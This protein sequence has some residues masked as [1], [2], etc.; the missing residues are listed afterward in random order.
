MN[1]TRVALRSSRS[2]R[3]VIRVYDE[4][5]NVD[6][7]EMHE[8]TGELKEGV[9]SSAALVAQ[10]LNCSQSVALAVAAVMRAGLEL[11]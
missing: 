7:I 6:V 10:Y 11:R 5:G 4:A 9:F 3:A 2:S 1:P 8:H